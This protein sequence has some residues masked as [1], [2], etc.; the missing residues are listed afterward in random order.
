MSEPIVAVTT[1][2]PVMVAASW[3]CQCQGACGDP[4]ERTAGTC[5]RRHDSFSSK[6]GSRI[7]LIAAPADLSLPTAQA[8]SLLP[9]QLRAWC[10]RC[11]SAARRAARRT[12]APEPG[13]G[14]FD[15]TEGG[16]T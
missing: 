10:P 1:W 5:A 12:S 8:A 3:V 16:G 13:P 7:H 6:H 4:H 2:R 15:L 14:L 9:S 11:F